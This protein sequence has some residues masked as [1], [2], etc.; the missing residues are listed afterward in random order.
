[1]PIPRA[2]MNLTTVAI[3]EKIA[4]ELLTSRQMFGRSLDR[5]TSIGGRW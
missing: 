3:A 1:M 2:S 4:A 5:E